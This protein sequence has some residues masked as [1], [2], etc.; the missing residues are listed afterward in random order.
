MN[1]VRSIRSTCASARRSQAAL[2]QIVKTVPIAVP[3]ALCPN[4]SGASLQ[5][6]LPTEAETMTDTHPQATPQQTR[7]RGDGDDL[8]QERPPQD[9]SF[10]PEHLAAGDLIAPNPMTIGAGLEVEHEAVQLGQEMIRAGQRAFNE[11]MTVWRRSLEPYAAARAAMSSWYEDV[12]RQ[13][14]GFGAVRPLRA[15]R[16]TVGAAAATVMGGPPLDL[17]EL[18]DCYRVQVEV[19]G[20]DIED[21]HLSLKNGLL[22]VSGHKAEAVEEGAYQISERRYGR[23]ER[24]APV[25][26]K[27]DASRIDAQLGKGILTVTLPKKADAIEPSAKIEVRAAAGGGA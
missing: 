22:I 11:V 3:R 15:A 6:R 1:S 7:R 14:T 26:D 13:T 21:I 5:F 8:R 9:R 24:A 20:V 25:P 2:K 23:F 27:V 18:Q 16:P 4:R 10:T 19:P 12:L 17:R